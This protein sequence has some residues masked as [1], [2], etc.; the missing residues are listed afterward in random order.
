MP[1]CQCYGHTN[2]SMG[3]SLGFGLSDDELGNDRLSEG[4]SVAYSYIFIYVLFIYSDS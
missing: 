4:I 3:E 1:L 2:S